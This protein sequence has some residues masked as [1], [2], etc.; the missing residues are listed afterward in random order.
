MNE[1]VHLGDGHGSYVGL[2]HP[3]SL[4]HLA[5]DV[6]VVTVVAV[7]LLFLLGPLCVRWR[8]GS[9][10]RSI[11]STSSTTSPSM[12]SSVRPARAGSWLRSCRSAYFS[13]S[14]SSSITM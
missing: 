3:T 11:A 12:K 8:R 6:G 1:G 7:G 4:R 9:L 14:A 10:H 5:A 2:T 13:S